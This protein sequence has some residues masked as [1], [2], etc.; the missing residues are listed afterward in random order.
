MIEVFSDIF[1]G[2]E[3]DYEFRVKGKEG[4]A[5]IHAC[6]EPYHRDEL[7][8][9]GKGAPK[10]HPEYLVAKRGHRLI[11]N[12]VDAE[13]PE[14]FNQ[15]MIEQAMDFIDEQREDGKKIL[16][17]CNQ[18]ESRSPSLGLLYLATRT[19]A[20]P[21]ESFQEAEEEFREICPSYNPKAGI[22][23]HIMNHWNDYLN[24]GKN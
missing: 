17:H 5:I 22:R 16:I 13:Y 8:Y 20:L 24:E 23:R 6:K 12:M 1:V 15:G 18:G 11:L 7:G 14:Y 9:S 10:N 3:N 21:E 4:W 2:D 19:E